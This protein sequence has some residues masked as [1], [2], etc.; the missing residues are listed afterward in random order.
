MSLYFTVMLVSRHGKKE[1]VVL[2]HLSK[3]VPAHFRLLL[4]RDLLYHV[5]I[6]FY[7]VSYNNGPEQITSRLSSAPAF[8]EPSLFS[9]N[10][11]GCLPRNSHVNRFGS[12]VYMQ[13]IVDLYLI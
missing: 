2:I 13:Y 3:V 1:P 6:C 7:Q 4:E 11:G 8:Q 10:Q 9:Q 12:Q 5:T